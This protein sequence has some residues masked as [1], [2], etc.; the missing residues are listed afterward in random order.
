MTGPGRLAQSIAAAEALKFRRQ[1]FV[2]SRHLT[3]EDTP[4]AISTASSPIIER[5]IEECLQCARWCS[6]CVE[7]SLSH[8]PAKMAECIRLCHECA[9]VCDTCVTLLSGNSRF[10]YQLCAVCAD[11]CEACA[12]ECGKYSNM[13]TMRECAE[14]CRRCAKTCREVAKSVPVRHVA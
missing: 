5:C 13:E 8:D 1:P 7:E 2:V 10:A 3:P 12:I 14:A 9:P 4:M 11:M 6:K